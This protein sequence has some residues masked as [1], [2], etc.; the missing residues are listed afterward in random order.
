MAWSALALR[1]ASPATLSRIGPITAEQARL[2]AAAAAATPATRWRVILTDAHGHALAVTTIP[3]HA[4][5]APRPA[6]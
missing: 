4:L 5:A 1:S 6:P 3:R 2:L